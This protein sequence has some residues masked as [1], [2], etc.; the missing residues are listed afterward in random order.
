LKKDT[1]PQ[2]IIRHTISNGAAYYLASAAFDH[3]FSIFGD[4]RLL[5]NHN[6]YDTVHLMQDILEAWYANGQNPRI[7]N[8][9]G[10]EAGLFMWEC[11]NENDFGKLAEMF[12]G[13]GRAILLRIIKQ[14]ERDPLYPSMRH[15]YALEIADRLIHDRQISAYIARQ[16]I[17]LAPRK[18]I[19]DED[20]RD[21]VPQQFCYRL[22]WPA[23]VRPLLIAR[24]RGKCANC[25]TDMTM[26]LQANTHI[27][28]IFALSEGGCNDIVNLQLLCE[29]C[30]KKKGTNY[31][32]VKTSVPSYHKRYSRKTLVEQHRKLRSIF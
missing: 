2:S 3:F 7:D 24:D 31:L 21:E 23:F 18:V 29:L 19:V 26:E 9:F 8:K 4:E 30:N 11:D 20:F 10:K 25:K 5:D 16:L 13:P 14:C 12:L 15:T 27:D 22:K 28:H 17:R 6:I 32:A 1:S